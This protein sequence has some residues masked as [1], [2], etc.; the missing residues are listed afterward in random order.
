MGRFNEGIVFSNSKCVG[1]NACK[2][3]CPSLGANVSVLE[4]GQRRV[5]VSKKCIECGLCVNA[6]AHRAREFRDD[7]EVF[8]EDLKKGEKIAL[9]IDPAFYIDYGENAFKFLGFLK[10][11]GATAIYDVSY[12]ADISAYMHARYVKEHTGK[13]KQ[14]RSY[15]A[16]NC[17]AIESFAERL[18]PSII[19]LL[20]P[21]HSPVDCT[22]IY[23]KKYLGEEAKLAYISP[24][25]SRFSSNF[26]GKEDNF[27]SYNVTFT[28]F[29]TYYRKNQYACAAARS[30]LYS[31]GPGNIV[32]YKSG[33]IDFLSLFFDKGETLT[34]LYGFNNETMQSLNASAM[35]ENLRHPILAT[36]S[37]CPSGCMFGNG[38]RRKDIEAINIMDMYA[39]LRRMF[40]RLPE[41]VEQGDSY[42]HYM[43]DRYSFLDPEDFACHFIDRYKQ[44]YA[45]PEDVINDIFLS[46]HKEDER[47]RNIN[48]RSCGYGGCREMAVAVASGYARVQ[49]CVHYM[50]DDYKYTALLDRLTG[51]YNQMGFRQ[52]AT[53]LL[54]N[55][56][57]K[58]YV[59]YVGNINRLKNINDLYGVDIGDKVICHVAKWLYNFVG[60]KGIVSRYG[61]GAFAFLFEYN[62]DMTR[63]Y[64]AMEN[65][66]LKSLGIYFPITMR[67]GVIKLKGNSIG[68]SDAINLCSYAAEKV[69]DR[70]RNVT[71][72]YD[73]TM[74]R[75]MQV[76]TEITLM[77]RDAMDNGEFVLYLQPQYNHKTGKIVGAEALS[78]W[79]K[80]DGSIVSPGLFIPVFEKNGFIKDMDKYVWESA[81]K[82]VKSWEESGSVIVPISVNISRVSLEND[83]IVDTIARLSDK[84]PIDKR[85]LYFEITESAYMNDQ[86]KL[87][88]RIKRIRDLGFEIAMDD[89]G[90][91]YSSLNSLK[92]TPL[93]VLKLDM[94]FLRGGTNLERGNE[95]VAHMLH[96]AKSLNLKIVGEGVETLA[97]ADFLTEKGC[98]VIQGFYYAKP[99][100]I[101]EYQE[102]LKKDAQ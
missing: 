63:A 78:R 97:Q 59:L 43:Q 84:Y 79:L 75:E 37:A 70:T 9:L 17:A 4:E 67:H 52:K 85:H 92:D 42:Y 60:N 34:A 53:E 38:A 7:Y 102:R 101:G 74:H 24:C 46:M 19:P 68:I 5:A 87:I 51:L 95:I 14:C 76:E 90:S 88:E 44:S 20:V 41:G 35:S 12:G 13:R 57:D 81:F 56:P 11:M 86:K 72:E 18:N 3:V 40:F 25:I 27:I 33:F 94:G 31:D 91:G 32:G 15:I 26:N 61:G 93:D 50:N 6:C 22:A 10:S 100:P 71:A 65:V 8:F 30:T 21:V 89:F 2:S 55:A 80:S 49:D 1:C 83:E 28:G 36:V 48:C 64:E 99:M 82:L 54:E 98:D 66:D 96:M 62:P 39:K 29:M 69:T 45:V 16:N 77:M 58:E 73:D 47:K 23:V